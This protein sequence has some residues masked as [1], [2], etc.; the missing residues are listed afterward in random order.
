M[1]SAILGAN[2]TA[3]ESLYGPLKGFATLGITAL[4]TVF[5]GMLGSILYPSP[6]G[7]GAIGG[8][9]LSGL[10][11][12][13]F[14]CF[15]TGFF[16]E[17]TSEKLKP[18]TLNVKNYL[19]HDLAVKVGGYG[20]FDLVLTVHEVSGVRI[21]GQLP[22]QNIDTYV[23]VEC[24]SNPIKRTCVKTSGKFNEQ[25]KL[26]VQASDE[27]I[28]LRVKDQD[29]FGS[30]DIGYVCVDILKDIIQA[31]FPKQVDF[32]LEAGETDRM[33]HDPGVRAAINLSFDYTDKYPNSVRPEKTAMNSDYANA[34]Y[35]SM[36]YISQKV[37]NPGSRHL[38][39]AEDLGVGG[40]K[41][42]APKQV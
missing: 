6:P 22:W 2:N 17:L 39:E 3:V 42:R 25:F 26:A 24:G 10:T 28:V 30:T 33:R 7:V 23:E 11:C 8:C 29:I 37:F 12:L 31:D 15:I 34:E 36:G 4:G 38:F 41:I 5:G 9:L 16:W 19:R 32:D 27:M 40:K 35:G 18:G 14:G 13:I 21:Q 20:R 1:N